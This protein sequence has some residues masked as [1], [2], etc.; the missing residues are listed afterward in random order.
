MKKIL[1]TAIAIATISTSVQ[2]VE[3]NNQAKISAVLDNAKLSNMWA[4]VSNLWIKN[5][6][7]NKAT[8][9]SFGHKLCAGTK[10]KNIGAYRITF[11]H[12]FGQ[13]EITRIWC[14]NN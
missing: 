13:G 14:S 9:E 2:A 5:S 10:G 3:L 6:G 4:G 1:L 7:Y 12:E 8:L 11:W